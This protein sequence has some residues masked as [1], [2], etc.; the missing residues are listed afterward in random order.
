MREFCCTL[1]SLGEEGVYFLYM[2]RKIMVSKASGELQEF[3]ERKLLTSLISAGADPM[4]AEEIVEHIASQVFEGME[5][6]MIHA[7]ALSML[8]AEKKSAAARYNLK[9]AIAALGPGGVPF[10]HFIA[11]MF[12]TKGYVTQVSVT[13]SGRCIAHEVDIVLS[14]E[15]IRG[16]VECKFHVTAGVKCDVKIPLY[17]HS[18]FEDIESFENRTNHHEREG[19]V[20]TNTRFTEDALAY[21]SCVGL[22]ML[23]WNSGPLGESLGRIIDVRGLHPITCLTT[24]T[25]EQIRQFLAD[26]I[27]LCRDLLKQPTLVDANVIAEAKEVCHHVA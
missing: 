7:R 5:T 27:V 10:E 24:L 9:R 26:G 22:K 2:T 16:L 23:G 4:L 18:R 17:I 25:P 20:V 19:W 15:N 6:K 14:K 1:R 3:S 13:L 21:G 11:R 12:E 8:K